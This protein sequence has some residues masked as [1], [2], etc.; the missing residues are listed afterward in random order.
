MIQEIIQQLDWAEI[1]VVLV[2]SVG[3]TLLVWYRS[4]I[5]EWRK[6]WASVLDGLRSIP[7]LK[8]DMK[9]IRYYVAPNGGGSMM[10][11]LKRT[12]TAVGI[13]TE[14][15]DLVVR[16]MIV[17][18]DSDEVGRFQCDGTGKNTYVNQTYARW[19]AVGKADLM[20]WNFVNYV[21]PEDATRVRQLWELCRSE[22]RQ[23]NAVH[24]MIASTGAVIE[25]SVL[26]TP[27]PDGPP[28]K[29]WVGTIRRID[30]A[31]KE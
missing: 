25:V 10:D 27:I 31:R 19:L 9:G 26:A 2:T 20:E 3:G 13:L 16:T 7:E 30:H 18:N 8:A 11:S 6:F 28:A 23:Y 14:Q 4:K 15:V 5:K 1:V 29:R 12:E 21:H 17:E 22:H 24:K